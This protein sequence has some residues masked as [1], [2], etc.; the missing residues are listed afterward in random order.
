[1]QVETYSA[2]AAGVMELPDEAEKERRDKDPLYRLE[3]QQVRGG[4]AVTVSA[5][6]RSK[7]PPP[8]ATARVACVHHT[9]AHTIAV[10]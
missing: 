2:K 4:A 3:Y 9:R 10:A 1:M 6:A 5:P 7:H 8:P